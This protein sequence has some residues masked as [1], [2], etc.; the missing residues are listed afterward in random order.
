MRP[1]Q[2]LLLACCALSAL[3]GCSSAPPP[4]AQTFLSDYSR[5]DPVNERVTRFM[6]PEI[7]DYNL[8]IVDPPVLRPIKDPPVLTPEQRAEIAAYF[9][10]AAVGVL[11]KRGKTVTDQ[12]GVGVARI[13]LGVTDVR[14]AKWYLKLHPASKLAGA[15]LGAATLETEV[16]DS[17]TGEQIGASVTR[18][19]GDQFQLDQ[20]SSINDVMDVIDQWAEAVNKT[21]DDLRDAHEGS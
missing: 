11:E 4:P 1:T 16:I 17:V 2:I 15:G 19:K 20:F 5:L 21:L 3:V 9:R 13:R 14:K 10:E 7:V 12:P 6:S 18:A 8:F